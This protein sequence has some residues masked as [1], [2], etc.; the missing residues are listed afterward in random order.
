MV[1][2]GKPTAAVLRRRKTVLMA[3]VKRRLAEVT[4]LDAE[5]GLLVAASAEAE[6]KCFSGSKLSVDESERAFTVALQLRS[7]L[8]M[9]QR[10]LR[11]LHNTV[12]LE[13][14]AILAAEMSDLT[15]A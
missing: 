2:C 4:A 7:E 9:A 8:R 1:K 15:A 13:K 3:A 6:T 5:V 10:T 12:A 11:C 14:H